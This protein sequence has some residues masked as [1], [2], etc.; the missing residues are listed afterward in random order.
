MRE[1]GAILGERWVPPIEWGPVRGSSP[2]ARD[3][4]GAGPD[5]GGAPRRRGGHP[6]AGERPQVHRRHSAGGGR[7]ATPPPPS[8]PRSCQTDPR[9]KFIEQIVRKKL[10]FLFEFFVAL[11]MPK[12][13]SGTRPFPTGATAIVYVI[14]MLCFSQIV[15]EEQI[16][17]VLLAGSKKR[18]ALPFSPFKVCPR[19]PAILIS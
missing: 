14:I 4:A 11:V 2:L 9:K 18:P 10:V 17:P 5:P 19:K 1:G 16:I 6:V 3:G 15:Q 12:N 13:M 8:A 7:D